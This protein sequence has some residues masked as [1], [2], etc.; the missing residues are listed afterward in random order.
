[1]KPLYRALAAVSFAAAASIAHGEEYPKGPITLV[2]PL[3]PGDA[4]DIAGR[5]MGEELSRLLKVPVVAVNRP[6]AGGSLAV[7]SV[8][9]AG[10][11]GY[12]I[13]LS[14]NGALTFR[15]VLEPQAVSYDPARNLTPLGLA[16]RTPSVLAVQGESPFRTFAEMIDYARKNPGK[17]RIGTEIG[18][19]SCRERVY[20]LV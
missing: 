3:A 13:L 5:A 19:A 17:L 18:R 9:R 1:M 10:K 14:Q 11:D 2:I 7:D 8:V 4:T 16:I 20:V 6:G 12:T 15:R